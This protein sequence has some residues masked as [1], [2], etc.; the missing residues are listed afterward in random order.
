MKRTAW[1]LLCVCIMLFALAGCEKTQEEVSWP[2]EDLT[3]HFDVLHPAVD[4]PHEGAFVYAQVVSWQQI[5][6]PAKN[7]DSQAQAMTPVLRPAQLVELRV[8][9]S[10][11][12]DQFEEGQTVY[13]TMSGDGT[14]AVSGIAP[15]YYT[16]QQLIMYISPET[17]TRT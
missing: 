11:F 4:S 1:L 9:K 6:L 7:Y 17:T 14:H 13:L 3:A 12:G 2:I 10:L 5:L 8:G 16:G 15:A